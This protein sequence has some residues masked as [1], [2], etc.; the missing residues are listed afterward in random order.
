M[1]DIPKY[2]FPYGP[3]DFSFPSMEKLELVAGGIPIVRK[4]WTVTYQIHHPSDGYLDTRIIYVK[5]QN[6]EQ[7]S[8]NTISA[9]GIEIELDG[10]VFIIEEMWEDTDE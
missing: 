10:E 8:K 4:N 9:D 3:E 2:D 1:K 6:V 7:L 5:A